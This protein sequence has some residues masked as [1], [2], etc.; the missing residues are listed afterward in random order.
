M[1]SCGLDAAPEWHYSFEIKYG[2]RRVASFELELQPPPHQERAFELWLQHAVGR[3]LFEDVRAYALERVDPGLSAEARSAAEKGIN[4][5]LY[6]LMMVIDGVTGSL[7]NDTQAVELSV[8]ARLLETDSGDVVAE[9]D[10]REGDGMCMGYHGWLDGDYGED[11]VAIPKPP[12][13]G[14]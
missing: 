6:G 7:R 11:L 1:R 5:A 9:V 10:L 12:E 3:I 14:A 8:T 4:D 2:A 13:F